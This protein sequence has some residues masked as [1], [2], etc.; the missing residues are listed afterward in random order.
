IFR[1]VLHFRAGARIMLGAHPSPVTGGLHCVPLRAEGTCS[2]AGPKGG[3]SAGGGNG[4]GKGK[5][6]NHTEGGP[7]RGQ[8]R[9]TAPARRCVYEGGGPIR[10]VD[11]VILWVTMPPA[12]NE[13][14]PR[15]DSGHPENF[16]ASKKCLAN[17]FVKSSLTDCPSQR[18]RRLSPPTP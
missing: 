15:R 4:R 13:R 1:F 17:R 10:I 8:R 5:W 16:H 2:P 14:T 18:P 3:G 12:R 9:Q 7:R 6:G 11:W